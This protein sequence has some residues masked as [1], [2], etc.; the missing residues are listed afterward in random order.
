MNVWSYCAPLRFLLSTLDFCVVYF[1]TLSGRCALLSL[2]VLGIVLLLRTTVWKSSVFAKG[3]VWAAVF[4]ALWMGKLTIYYKSRIFLPIL[5]WQSWCS[6]YWW[7]RYGYLSGIMAALILLVY[8]HRK[9][10][11]ILRSLP[12][13]SIYGQRVLI[14]DIPISP[15]SAGLLSPKIVIPMI[16][17]KQLGEQDLK[18]ILL[19]ERTHIRLGHLWY[20]FLWDLLCVLLWGNPF[21][22]IVKSKLRE[23]M[24]QICDAVTIRRSGQDAVSYGRVILKSLTL[25]RAETSCLS[26]TFTGENDFTEA[27]QRIR[28]VR[29]Y[30]TYSR[31]HAAAV[32]AAALGF[33]FLAAF[34]IHQASYPHYTELNGYTVIYVNQDIEFITLYD[35]DT[36][37]P[38]IVCRGNYVEIDNQTLR[39]HLPQN[40]PKDGFYYIMWGG[41]MKVPGIGGALNSVWLDGMTDEPTRIAEF[42]DINDLLYVRLIKW[43]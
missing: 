28:M 1:M 40:T 32:C 43:L 37:P 31:R 29:D 18:T 24:E 3:A 10:R 35:T 27:K 6:G 11:R 38:P 34:V 19:H 7:V 22:R 21:L 42:D 13:A 9:L 15:F 25:L 36:E 16:A 23:D 14:C 41:F 4:P 2:P 30:R 8:R 12:T 33:L 20:F 5:L 39:A 17:R 26:A